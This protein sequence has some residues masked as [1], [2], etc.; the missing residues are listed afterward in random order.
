M[1]NTIVRQHSNAVLTP[2]ARRKMA[3]LM[4]E[5]AWSVRATAERFQVSVKTAPEWCDRYICEG[6]SGLLDRSSRSRTSPMSTPAAKQ[7]E[8]TGT[9][10]ASPQGCGV[11]RTRNRLSSFYCADSQQRWSGASQTRRLCHPDTPPQDV[12]YA[13]TRASSF[14]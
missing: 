6:S 3:D 10:L 2:I 5:H 9:T 12:M 13:T 1:V 11:D 14:M 4:L 7:A 8:V